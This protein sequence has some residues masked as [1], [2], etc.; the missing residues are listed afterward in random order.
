M[1]DGRAKSLIRRRLAQR[2]PGLGLERRGK[3]S[4]LG[5]FTGMITREAPAVWQRLGGPRALADLG[6]VD[7]KALETGSEHGLVGQAGGA[8]RLW[9]LLNLEG[10]VQPR[11]VSERKGH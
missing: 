3:V 10:W 4:A 7:R 8:G 11:M 6:I 9:T 5:V 1:A 2:L